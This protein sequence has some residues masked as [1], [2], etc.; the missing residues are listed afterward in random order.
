MY[1]TSTSFNTLINH[2]KN[3]TNHYYLFVIHL[4][5]R[6]LNALSDL[7]TKLVAKLLSKQQR[8]AP[9]LKC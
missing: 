6:Q 8:L 7:D 3:E 5:A 2:F 1:T 9:S 4:D